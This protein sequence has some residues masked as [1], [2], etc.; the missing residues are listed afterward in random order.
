MRRSKSSPRCACI[1]LALL[2]LAGTSARAGFIQWSYNW[3]PSATKITAG[4]GWLTLTNEPAKSAAGN[5]NTVVTNIRAFS[6]ASQNS[7]DQFNHAA[8][9]STL[10]LKDAASN[11]TGNLTFSG[12]FSGALTSSNSNI[13]NT[14]TSPT[15]QTLTLG[16]NT[17]TV[18]MGMFSPPGPTG[19]TNAGS[20]NAVVSVVPGNNG[21]G[22]VIAAPEPATLTLATLA[23]PCAG[24]AGWRKRKRRGLD[25]PVSVA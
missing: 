9:S 12:F 18:T 7:P 17:Y 5:S 2:L 25:S 13:T 3:T 10:Q 6:T 14:F 16:G 15:T 22:G 1:A 20:L 24:L 8:F 23:L 4:S 21:G 19:A 11:A